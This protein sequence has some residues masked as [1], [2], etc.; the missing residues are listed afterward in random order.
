MARPLRRQTIALIA[1]T[2]AVALL[3]AGGATA[4]PSGRINS[5]SI[6][7]PAW[8]PRTGEV[9]IGV[10]VTSRGDA[11]RV[12]ARLRVLDSG[13]H[14]RWERT[15][16]RDGLESATYDFSFASSVSDL[17]LA[18][19]VY[20]AEAT[21]R[22][23]SAKAIERARQFVV[24]DPSAAKLPVSIVVRVA[25]TPASDDASQAVDAVRTAEDTSALA[26]LSLVR[27]DLHL[28]AAIP[29]FLLDEWSA[30]ATDTA[31]PTAA[32]LEALRSAVAGGLPLL[33]GMYGEP[34]L[35]SL[36][37]ASAEIER[38]ADAGDGARHAAFA[39]DTT[40]SVDA[41]GF[42][43][44]SGLVPAAAG[45]ALSGR[46]VSFLLV[47]AASLQAEGTGSVAPVRY[48]VSVG[49]GRESAAATSSL[50]ALVIDRAL[51][52]HLADPSRNDTLTAALFAR[53]V[54]KSARFAV[55][56]EVL[57]GENGV[58]TESLVE[59]L[60]SLSRV[61]WIRLVDAPSAAVGPVAG[62]AVLRKQPVDRT[63]APPGL[64]TAIRLA[65]TRVDGLVAAT[66][67][68]SES[69]GALKALMLAESR[70]WAGTDGAW[71]QAD[72]ALA[73][74]SVADDAAWSV[75]SKIKVAAPAVTLPGSSGKVPVS[76]VNGSDRVV[77]IVL[78]AVSQEM[79]VRDQHIGATLEPG[80]NILSVPV[81][82]GTA[83]SGRLELT[84]RA[85]DL[86]LARASTTVKASYLD[87]IA[88][89]SAVVLVLVGLL[90]YIRRKMARSAQYAE[91]RDDPDEID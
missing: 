13:G 88:L 63:P 3:P 21:V 59:S 68:S 73:L 75:L 52:S 64:A 89:L 25:A 6:V 53:S 67:A 43:V 44:L 15:Q 51:S 9:A 84:V 50:T 87:R 23:G 7:A 70:A 58:P 27:P 29:P 56:L 46:G 82:L 72:G 11:D 26:R 4:A 49:S 65:R 16:A 77:T 5:V 18:P 55:V 57:V 28:T 36:T 81:A 37:T 69:T 61:P 54:S 38:Q 85:G 35:A 90:F 22:S 10:R 8:I 79:R 48:R 80:E 1:L 91:D 20:R 41:T 47:N 12:T 74:A 45:P 19:G 62:N 42:G 17:G 32:A 71:T 33:R 66:D 76:V 78:D 34:D 83:T 60:D 2:L 14:I 86:E 40:A 31:A 30:A 24:F 39:S